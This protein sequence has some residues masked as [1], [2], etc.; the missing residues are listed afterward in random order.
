MIAREIKLGLQDKKG[1]ILKI[2]PVY[3]S[4]ACAN[5][6]FS[7]LGTGVSNTNHQHK[8]NGIFSQ[9]DGSCN[10]ALYTSPQ[11]AKIITRTGPLNAWL[12]SD[13]WWSIIFRK[14]EDTTTVTCH[15]HEIRQV[16]DNDK[17]SRLEFVYDLINSKL[18]I[19]L[20]VIKVVVDGA[21]NKLEVLDDF[22]PN[23]DSELHRYIIWD[24]KLF[25][26]INWEIKVVVASSR[27]KRNMKIPVLYAINCEIYNNDNYRALLKN[28]RNN[29]DIIKQQ[30]VPQGNAISLMSYAYDSCTVAHPL[31]GLL[32]KNKSIW[33]D[34][35]DNPPNLVST[36]F[37]SE[38][39]R[40]SN[41][42]Q[43]CQ[44]ISDYY[45]TYKSKVNDN[46]LIVCFSDFKLNYTVADTINFKGKALVN[47]FCDAFRNTVAIECIGL[48]EAATRSSSI[49]SKY[50]KH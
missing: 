30:L 48:L 10:R 15:G 33:F 7:I 37:E 19:N 43:M 42:D 22:E 40:Y 39:I 8:M 12:G 11:L 4:V 9:I 14:G 29:L 24:M 21:G 2:G 1:S 3:I 17:Q 23:Y 50:C 31:K 5:E 13:W 49:N 28:Y 45:D 47:I 25:T 35:R 36:W 6:L 16:R 41:I 26:I 27:D 44:S 20:A 34:K 38:I 32:Y 18:T 46:D